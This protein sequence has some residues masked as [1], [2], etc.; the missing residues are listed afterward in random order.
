MLAQLALFVEAVDARQSTHALPSALIISLLVTPFL[1]RIVGAS[2]RR[3]F[4]I[5]FVALA[6]HDVL[7]VLQATDRMLW[8]PLSH[9]AVWHGES[10]LP[11]TPLKEAIGFGLPCMLAL[12]IR[13]FV[14]P[15]QS[16]TL[17]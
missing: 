12:I 15:I 2:A 11:T 8:W 7:D 5:T 4:I 16:V 1:I 13:Y 9:H 14:T 10:L 6:L 17:G 3:T